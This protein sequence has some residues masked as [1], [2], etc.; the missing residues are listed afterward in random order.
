ML[1]YMSGT[2]PRVPTFSLWLVSDRGSEVV[3]ETTEDFLE[4]T[5]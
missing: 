1:V 5:W 4:T 3:Y 2:L